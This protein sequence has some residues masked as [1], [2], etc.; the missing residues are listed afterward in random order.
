[1]SRFAL[2]FAMFG[3]LACSGRETAERVDAQTPPPVSSQGAADAEA[4]APAAA[5]SSVDP[6]VA[7]CL[8]LVRRSEFQAA[9]DACLAALDA[10][11][12]NAEVKSAL[13]RAQ[14]E[15]AAQQAAA[16]TADQVASDIKEAARVP[17]PS[18]P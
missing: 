7:G 2:V 17:A 10:H 1:M 16:E 18:K 13:A 12:E 5:P 15:T 11:P 9:L 3:L 6:Q 4:A 8:D 14:A